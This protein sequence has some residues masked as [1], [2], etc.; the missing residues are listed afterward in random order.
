M[1]GWQSLQSRAQPRLSNNFHPMIKGA[2]ETA[3]RSF[4]AAA[5][6]YGCTE[7]TARS[8]TVRGISI[9]AKCH[10]QLGENL[11]PF[12]RSADGR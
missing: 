11:K 4:L 3:E 1:L 5:L 10:S 9:P 8:R 2:L 12:A 7:I 6:D